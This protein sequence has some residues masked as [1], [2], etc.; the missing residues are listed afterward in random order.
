MR[1]VAVELDQFGPAR[2]RAAALGMIPSA[3]RG[4]LLF[5]ADWCAVLV[6]KN[7]PEGFVVE[8]EFHATA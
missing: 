4:R 8:G 6:V 5:A 3:C 7:S 1:V 2:S